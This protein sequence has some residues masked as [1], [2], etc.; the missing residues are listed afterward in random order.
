MEQQRRRPAITA[1]HRLIVC[2]AIVATIFAV[3]AC[4]S[5]VSSTA[6]REKNAERASA[7]AEASGGPVA[8]G[9]ADPGID[10][11]CIYGHLQS[12]PESFHY[13]YKKTESDGFNVDQEA[14]ITPQTIDGFRL[15]PDGV[16]HPLHAARSDSSSWQAAL[17]NLTGI[18]GMSSTVSTFNHNSAM[19]RESDGGLVNGYD[20][21]HYS[22]DTARWD[23]ATRQMLGSFALGPGGFDKGD[24]WVT[25][26]GCPVKIILDDEMHKKD[27]SLIEKVHYEEAMVKK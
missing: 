27:G 10:L 23:E 3:S 19:R 26:E 4:T 24:T 20:T 12:P 5:K 6:S 1:V 16:Q 7:A 17:A 13:V 9:N 11:N 15:Q 18:S 22:I 21:I 8:Q 2:T 14:D 25:K